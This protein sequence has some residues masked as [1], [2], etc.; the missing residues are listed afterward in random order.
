MRGVFHS[1]DIAQMHAGYSPNEI[2]SSDD[3]TRGALLPRVRGAV[4][5]EAVFGDRRPQLV[6]LDEVD[7]CDAA[8]LNAVL[9]Y[10]LVCRYG[11]SRICVCVFCTSYKR[12]TCES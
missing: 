10:L 7:G 9:D 5:S 11:L 3:R 2:N 12:R 6:I 4:E 1:N 8:A